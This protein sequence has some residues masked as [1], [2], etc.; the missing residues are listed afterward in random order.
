MKKV[1]IISNVP[2][3]YR[4]DFYHYLQIQVTE[5]EWT[6]V[7]TSKGLSSREWSVAEDKLGNSVF[8]DSKVLTKK[9]HADTFHKVIPT[10]VS[11]ALDEINPDVV[12]GSEYNPAAIMAARWCRRRGRKYV[13]LTDGTRISERN[14]GLVQKLA[15]KYI[16]RRA[17][18]FIASSQKTKENQIYLGADPEKISISLLT[19]DIKP[20]LKILEERATKV[21]NDKPIGLYV[22]SLIGRKGIDLL[23]NACEKNT[24][25][26]KIWL[27]GSGSNE[28]EYRK[29]V[30]NSPKLSQMIKFKGYKEG[31]EL[32]DLYRDSDFFVFPTREDCF[33]LV[34][35]EAAAA[36][37]PILSSIYADGAYEIIADGVNGYMVDPFG[38]D[39][40]AKKLNEI[41]DNQEMLRITISHNRDML[42]KFTFEETAK[43]Y[44]DAVKSTLS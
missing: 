12:I 11:K 42:K 38:A 23:F 3:P 6:I 26:F 43:G 27:V 14:L 29:M 1:C 24:S 17:D 22:G 37:L 19:E 2:A 21:P 7:Y 20:Y 18:W 39:D 9:T 40:F 4:V 10:G 32:L 16:I 34:L 36:G 15:R 25:D 13:S 5:Y 30:A 8:L 31:Q 44:V 41:V 35:L 28:D 33:A